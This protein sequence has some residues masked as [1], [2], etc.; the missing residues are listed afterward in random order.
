MGVVTA[1][2]FEFAQD[3]LAPILSSNLGTVRKHISNSGFSHPRCTDYIGVHFKIVAQI[4]LH[5]LSSELIDLK[6]RCL[7]WRWTILVASQRIADP[8]NHPFSRWRRPVELTIRL[9]LACE[10]NDV[11]LRDNKFWLYDRIRNVIVIPHRRIPCALLKLDR[12]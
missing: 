9:H 8:E 10:V 2:H 7:L 1:S 6:A 3:I 12:K 11:L 4:I 5:I